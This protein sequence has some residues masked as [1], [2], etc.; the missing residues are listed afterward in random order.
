MAEFDSLKS[1][2]WIIPSVKKTEGTSTNQE[3]ELVKPFE[4]KEPLLGAL[5]QEQA[6]QMY[7]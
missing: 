1:R 4:V 6:M 5:K 2:F 7:P 3:I